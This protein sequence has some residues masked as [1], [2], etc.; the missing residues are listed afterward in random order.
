MNKTELVTYIK[1]TEKMVSPGEVGT[2]FQRAEM[3]RKLPVKLQR[4]IIN[5]GA[6]K[7]PY[8][9]F[10]V[11][12]YSFFLAYE[13][14]NANAANKSLPADYEL[15]PCAM[16]EGSEPRFCAILAAFNVH[17]TV[18]WGSRVEFYIIAR[19]KKTGLMSWI[20]A[21]Y[22]SNTISYD[23]GSGFLG[24]STQRSIVTT[25]Y[26]GDVII[27]VAGENTT[28]RIALVAN[29]MNGKPSPLH[30]RLWVE[31]N[32]SVD[33]GGYLEGQDSKPFGL[34]FDPREME[35]ALNIP[36]DAVNIEHNSFGE[37]MLAPQP[38]EAAC[39]PFAQHFITTSVPVLTHLKNEDDL[40]HAVKSFNDNSSNYA[41][42]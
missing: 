20:I 14:T 8:I 38:F 24:P 25:S 27:D 34:I 39:F 3:L 11:E 40:E 41:G 17:T 9:G 29:I 4:A 6:S 7:N 23:P 5:K 42:Q 19:N 35:H 16:F 15:M 18:F 13:I 10:I 1:N 33:Y 37:S 2:L 31:G 26:A 12:P 36:L 30:Q 28:N 21:D 32:L 22:E